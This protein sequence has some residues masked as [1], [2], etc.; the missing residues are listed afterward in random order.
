MMDAMAT[1]PEHRTI[2]TGNGDLALTSWPAATD[3]GR[4]APPV[5][6]VHGVNGWAASWEVVVDGVAG[7]RHLTAVD[8][9]GRGGSPPVGPW[10]VAAHAADVV[11]A[12]GH[13]DRPVTLAGHSFGCHVAACAARMA[14]ELVADLVL[15]DGGPP[16]SIPAGSDPEQMIEGAL[17]NILP[18][19]DGLGF[20]VS[21]DA[22]RADFTSM[23]VDD[24][25]TAS[26]AATTQ[27]LHVVRAGHGVAPGLPPIIGD[28]TMAELRRHRPATDEAVAHATH[29]SLLG[30][31]A[32]AVVEALTTI[33]RTGDQ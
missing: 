28:E 15:V 16:R 3:G 33:R 32:S 14:P 5:I 2:S 4:N 20:P 31:H 17:A 30:D 6:L 11:E 19:L 27:P 9:R 26:L 23:I 7:R 29:F 24:A 1:A 25:A 12:I 21:A 10:G 8:L 18:H 13:L 22:V